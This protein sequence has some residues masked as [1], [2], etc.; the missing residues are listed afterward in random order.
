MDRHCQYDR[1]YQHKSTEKLDNLSNPP[2]PQF[3]SKLGSALAKYAPDAD[4]IVKSSVEA[5]RDQPLEQQPGI[6]EAYA[7]AIATVCLIGIPLGAC[8]LLFALLIRN[9]SIKGQTMAM[10]G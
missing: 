7:E 5:I 6:K 8:C 9:K 2:F 4:A 3:A 1:E 10:A